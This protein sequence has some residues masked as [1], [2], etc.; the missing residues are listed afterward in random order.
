MPGYKKVYQKLF[1]RPWLQT[2]KDA[3]RIVLSEYRDYDNYIGGL[4]EDTDTVW[5]VNHDSHTWVIVAGTNTKNQ[6]AI[7]HIMNN[8]EVTRRGEL[9]EALKKLFPGK[10]ISMLQTTV[11]EVEL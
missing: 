4:P 3:K 8:D 10:K 2:I 9:V 1:G 6:R 7:L 5:Q 11:T